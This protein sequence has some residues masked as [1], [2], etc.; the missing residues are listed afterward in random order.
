MNNVFR[1]VHPRYDGNPYIFEVH[2]F[3]KRAIIGI[4]YRISVFAPRIQPVGRT[5]TPFVF[6]RS[7]EDSTFHPPLPHTPLV[8]FRGGGGQCYS[9]RS[10]SPVICLPLPSPYPH[11]AADT[12]HRAHSQHFGYTA[13]PPRECESK[14]RVNPG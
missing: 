9:R 8:S 3:I 7:N 1:L 14:P 12:A 6:T 13:L 4:E 2:V 5:P 10:A 11:T